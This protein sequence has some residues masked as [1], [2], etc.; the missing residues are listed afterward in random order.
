MDSPADDWFDYVLNENGT[1]VAYGNRPEDYLTDVLAR[2]ATATIR[3]AVANQQPFFLYIAPT[4]PH[5]PAIPAPRHADLFEDVAYPLR[6]SFDE[7]DVSDKPALIRDLPPLSPWQKE[8]I[9]R[10][11]RERLRSLQAVDDLVEQVVATLA[12]SAAID[13]TY[14]VYTSDNGWHMGEHRQFVGKT[15][16]YEEDIRVPLRVRGPGVPK[17][18]RLTQLVIN[19]DLAPSFADMAGIAPPAFVDGRSFLPLLADPIRPWRTGF[20]I[21][22]RERETQE[23]EGAATFDAIRT[24]RHLYVRYASGEIELYDLDDD[25]YQLDNIA[26]SAD[27]TLLATLER[28]ASALASCAGSYC[29]EVEDLPLEPELSLGAATPAKPG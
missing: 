6:P 25:P 7:A 22:R 27:K 9:Q 17:G 26:A 10:H 23:I 13:H 3:R 2:H 18:H 24:S 28:R 16:A 14:L 4:A 11:H 5:A 19:N 15:T 12:E 8:A 1:P 20:G 21:E 29:R